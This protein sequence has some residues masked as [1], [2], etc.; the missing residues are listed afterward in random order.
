MKSYVSVRPEQQNRD[1]VRGF[2]T[3]PVVRRDVHRSGRVWSELALRVVADTGDALVTA[4]ALGA[5]ARW[6]ALC[7][8]APR[9]GGPHGAHGVFEAMAAGEWELAAG[10][11]QETDLL[12]WRPPRS[13]FS[14]SAFFVPDGAEFGCT[15]QSARGSLD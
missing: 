12:L 5:Q 9:T 13:V 1:T 7:V 14:V 6:P 8:Q 3:G 10:M 2:E 4:C 15:S 11:W